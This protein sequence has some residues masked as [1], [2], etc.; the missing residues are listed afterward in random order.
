[1]DHYSK[2]VN[3]PSRASTARIIFRVLWRVLRR[4][5]RVLLRRPLIDVLI[6]LLV[7]YFLFGF[8]GRFNQ[9]QPLLRQPPM[10]FE[11]R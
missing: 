5:G 6:V 3:E 4:F 1:M 10:L 11:G 9:P 2:I 7:L 8:I